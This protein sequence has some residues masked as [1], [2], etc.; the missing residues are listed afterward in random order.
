MTNF[1]PGSIVPAPP[2]RLRKECELGVVDP[3]ANAY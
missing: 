1:V 2:V 3:T